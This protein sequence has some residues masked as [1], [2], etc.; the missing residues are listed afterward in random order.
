M[1]IAMRQHR[2]LRVVLALLLVALCAGYTIWWR[3]TAARIA[4]QSSV[5]IDASRAEGWTIETGPLAVGGFPFGWR[6]D[7]GAA[8]ATRPDGTRIE[9]KRLVAHSAL[10]SRGVR[11]DGDAIA[12]RLPAGA[13]RPVGALE[14]AHGEAQLD[15]GAANR[16]D[17]TLDTVSWRAGDAA[18]VTA[19]QAK[20]LREANNLS[21]S[22]DELHLPNASPLGDT[23]QKLELAGTAEPSLPQG[24][25]TASMQRWREAS[26][27]LQL[28]RVGL[29]WGP[30]SLTGEGTAALD[31]QGRI[32]L[33]GTARLTGW[34]ET[35]DAL[36]ATGSVKPN[37]G[38]LAKAG[39]GM[40]AKPKDGAPKEKGE[41]Q[42]A[43]AIQ[44][45]QLY[46]GGI[47]L[48]PAPVLKLF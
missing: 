34:S 47:R 18:P 10:W 23:V 46:L 43:V 5:W 37:G 4:A 40:L 32:E 33:A 26:G 3:S 28:G 2:A 17:V 45:G 7:A 20:L 12:L 48:G 27:V 6:L 16:I 24:L 13:S 36:V 31:A 25:D 35:I 38:A 21:A 11:V 19:R 8:T 9:S 22:L 29:L 44:D 30:L 39:L 15:F 41:V 1:F 42:I 14:A